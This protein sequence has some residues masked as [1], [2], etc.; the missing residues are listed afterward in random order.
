[1]LLLGMDLF[2]YI[3]A[4]L[5]NIDITSFSENMK[6]CYVLCTDIGFM[7]IIFTLFY[8]DI[9]KDFKAYFKNFGSNFVHSFGYYLIGLLMMYLCNYLIGIFFSDANSNNETMVRLLISKY[10]LYMLFSV[11]IYAPF[12]EEIIF[13][14]CIKDAVYTWGD[15]KVSKYVYIIIGGL[16][17]GT[18]HVLGVATSNYDYLYIISYMALGSTFAYIYCKSN[19]LFN[20]IVLH[21]LHNIVALAIYFIFG[22]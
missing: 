2:P 16:L 12:V 21:S 18:L 10:P 22:G 11:A 4:R 8:R 15:N 1:M 7:I 6:I 5:F 17:F 20:T 14:K 19:N 9:I 13:R 3:P